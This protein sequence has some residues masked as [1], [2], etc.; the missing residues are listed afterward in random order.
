MKKAIKIH[1]NG[2]LLITG[3]YLV[4]AG[5]KALAMPVCFGQDMTVD[6]I[7]QRNIEWKSSDQN[8]TWFSARFDQDTLAVISTD[9]KKIAGDLRRVLVAARRLNPEFLSCANGWKVDVKANYPLVW[10][11]GSSST[12]FY[13]V[14]E[15]AGVPVYELFRMISQ[16][17]GYDVA[18]AGRTG[19]LYYQVHKGQPDITPA[20]AGP[21]L[22][23]N[24][25]FVFLGTKQNSK[26][27]VAAFL[28]DQNY[29]EI[30]LVKI[31]RL[32]KEI[33]EAG[34][35]Y[36]LI[37]LVDEHEFILSTILKREPIA[38]HYRSF[39]G[40]VKSLGAWGGD[41]AM[42]VSGMEPEG[43]VNILHGLGF[44][45]VFSYNELEIQR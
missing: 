9:K 43:V 41:F 33:C 12:L 15:W 39:P 8:G 3:E 17:S 21:A 44:S 18:C 1:A 19:L 36:E 45:N 38:R 35:S 25:W 29:S 40:T 24:T 2:K 42:F 10:G 26:K 5:A 27:A 37:R 28:L 34:S 32:S 20:H 4:L 6:Q 14:A 22:R 16:G 7:P 23:N 11:L 13:L 31:S 30:D